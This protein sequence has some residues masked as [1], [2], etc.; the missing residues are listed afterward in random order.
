MSSP[1][2]GTARTVVARI[3]AHP[4]TMPSVL[5]AI[6]LREF[7]EELHSW[8]PETITMEMQEAFGQMPPE[9]HDKLLAIISAIETN[10][11]YS[12]WS[13]FEIICRTINTGEPYGS[14]ELLVAEMAWA[15][16]EVQLCD[17]TPGQFS[18]EIAAGVGKILADEGILT[19]P[20]SLS[21]ARMPERY[22]GSDTPSDTGK[23]ETLSGEHL[24]VVMNYIAEQS[25]LLMK[26]ISALPWQNDETLSEIVKMLA[27]R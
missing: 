17:E 20:P 12:S 6:A 3:V 1:I 26:Q 2:Q 7:G 18:E 10:S 24:A 9:N 19:P 21:F 14:D 22:Q 8:E 4:G 25:I 16:L 23:Q 15:I 11:F 13:V 27:S 5:Y